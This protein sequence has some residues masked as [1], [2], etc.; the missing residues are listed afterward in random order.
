MVVQK[1]RAMFMKFFL[2]LTLMVLVIASAFHFNY[3]K[4]LLD[5]KEYHLQG[6]TNFLKDNNN[7]SNIIWN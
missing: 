7:H 6:S 2:K 4:E 3:Y 5:K 1:L